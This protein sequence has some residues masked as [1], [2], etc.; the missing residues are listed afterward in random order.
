MVKI[1]HELRFILNLSSFNKIQLFR[2][3]KDI[4]VH[5]DA[6]GERIQTT[7]GHPFYAGGR[8]KIR[9]GKKAWKIAVREG[10]AEKRE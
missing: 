8:G 7:L 4:L 2:N 1:S 6:A 3:E 10:T 9:T 5:I